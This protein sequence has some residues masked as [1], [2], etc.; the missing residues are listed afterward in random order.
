MDNEQVVEKT[1]HDWIWCKN[2]KRQ[3]LKCKLVL[4]ITHT[5]VPSCQPIKTELDE[6]QVV[7][8]IVHI[9]DKE[10]LCHVS[11]LLERAARMILDLPE[12]CIKAERDEECFELVKKQIWK[13]YYIA[14]TN[15]SRVIEGIKQALKSKMGV[16]M[17]GITPEEAK[18]L[19]ALLE[20]ETFIPMGMPNE[21][22]F[23]NKWGRLINNLRPTAD[24]KV[25]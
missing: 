17:V 15:K 6:E 16:G 19:I 5:K 4:P 2:G 8:K 13:S 14:P 22:Y 3:C 18:D 1:R 11:I 21:Q 24:R 9:L 12:L 10:T 20:L 7:E 25:L 23:K